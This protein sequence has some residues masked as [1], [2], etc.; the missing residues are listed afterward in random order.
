MAVI[1][2]QQYVLH[3][4]AYDSTG[5]PKTGDASNITVRISKDGGALT[6]TTNTPAE[7]DATNAPG[8][9]RITLTATEM[10]AN[11]I[12]VVPKSST[13]GVTC[14]AVNIITERGRLD[15]AVSSRASSS[16]VGA[17]PANVWNY[18]P[19]SL[20]SDVTIDMTQTL[21]ASPTN[22]TVG[23]ALKKSSTNLDASVSSRSTLTAADVWS[24]TTRTL[25]SFGTLVSDI[26]SY[27]TR[28]LTSAVDINMGQALPASPSPNT[29]GEALKFADTR[30]DTAVS[31][32]AAPGDILITPANKLATDAAGK[33]SVG[34]YATGQSPS[35]Q[36]LV[37]P[38]NKLATDTAGRVTVA[39]YATGASPGEQV[40]ITPANKLATDV[41]GRVTVGTNADKTDYSLTASERSS[42]ASAVWSFVSEGTYTMLNIMRLISSALFGKVS[43]AQTNTP[44]FRDLLDTKNRITMTTDNDG[45]RTSVTLDGN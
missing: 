31:T 35:E 30:L 41:S 32:R 6:A 42:I 17:V 44:T 38:A 18:T 23:D 21:P 11:S 36:V 26:W 8:V 9:Y 29:T 45:N 22:N 28:T 37:T 14:T 25:T 1:R 34:S 20:S 33:V 10:D 40:L 12:L 3:F 19:R 15:V 5:A 2:A 43:G 7:V 16:E 13:S 4:Y 39:G 27:V 24:Y